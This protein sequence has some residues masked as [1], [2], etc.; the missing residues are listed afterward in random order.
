MLDQEQLRRLPFFADLPEPAVA[1]L[2]ADAEE[3]ALAAG[4]LI[5]EQNDEA[6]SVFFLLDGS[7]EVLLR[8]EGVGDLFM[9]S[10][11]EPDT[12]IGWSALRPPYRYTDSVRCE[13]STR[14]LRIPRAAFETV[15]AGDARTGYLLLHR[16]AAEV[17]RQLEAT[18][19]LLARR[20]AE[21]EGS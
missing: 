17:N 6:R 10:F 21:T 11:Q 8:Y 7:V 4:D 2:A 14:L 5:L 15:I 3:L 20:A 16:T 9:G 18:R 13:R 19:D 12:V 1:A